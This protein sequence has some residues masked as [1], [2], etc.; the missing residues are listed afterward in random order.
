MAKLIKVIC[1]EK[2]NSYS[3]HDDEWIIYDRDEVYEFYDVGIEYMDSRC[4]W[5]RVYKKY[6][7]T[8]AELREQQIKTILE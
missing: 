7:L 6:F 2:C 1:I 8:F 3:Y 5:H 4:D